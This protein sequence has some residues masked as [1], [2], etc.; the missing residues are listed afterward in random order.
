ML[1]SKA[2]DCTNTTSK[3]KI[4][5]SSKPRNTDGKKTSYYNIFYNCI[6]RLIIFK[7]CIN[8]IPYTINNLIIYS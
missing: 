5:G 8:L 6:K 1:S 3:T 2:M 7:N 4:L